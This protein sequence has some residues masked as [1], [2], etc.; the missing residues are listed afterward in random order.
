MRPVG[1]EHRSLGWASQ[2]VRWR[3]MRWA[4]N[5]GLSPQRGLG[6]NDL[7]GEHSRQMRRAVPIALACLA[8]LAC[9]PQP[10]RRTPRPLDDGGV[11]VT[12]DGPVGG[13]GASGTG[14]GPSGGG[15]TS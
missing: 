7:K 12:L 10:A 13:G 11:V 4:S 2:E 6:G 9:S 3:L 15:G 14:G 5:G 8:G 1:G